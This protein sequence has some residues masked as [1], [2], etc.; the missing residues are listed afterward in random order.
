MDQ[1]IKP[2]R[3]L[4]VIFPGQG[5]HSVGMGAGLAKV[6][7]AAR[8]VFQRAD[9][10]LETRLSKLCFE[11][12]AEELEHTT[13]QQ[14]ATFTTS[15]AWLAALRERWAGLDRTIEPHF[16]AGHSMGEFTAAVAAES[17]TFDEG[18]LLVK[19][20]GILM[21]QADKENPGGMA[22][23]LGLS[24][25]TVAAICAEAATDGYVGMATANCE[26]QNVISGAI[27]PLKRAMEL[28]EKAGARKVVRLQITMAS[29][30]PLMA[31]ASEG[32]T[33]L[34]DKLPLRDP[35]HPLVGNVN[36]EVLT[37]APQVY[38]ELRDQLTH[39]VRW[40]KSVEKMRSLG[41]DMFIECG[42]GN[43]LTRLVRR[44][45][46]EAN[47]LPLSDDYEGMLSE[48]F[49]LVEACAQ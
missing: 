9:E 32:M 1:V 13:N 34:L 18:L 33:R 17:L 3:K 40:Q 45:D 25:E 44:I 2:W 47:S 37:T 8:D 16:F 6:S 5:S 11:G 46:Y 4:A 24:E 35:R 20:R 30:S 31:K 21:D 14:P 12:P 49:K 48:N 36:A 22:S 39:G 29:H 10:V 26:G 7:K 43:V 23:V 38:V 27:G 15:I 42:P 19:E 41:A 28:A